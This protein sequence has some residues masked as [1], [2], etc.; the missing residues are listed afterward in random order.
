MKSLIPKKHID[1]LKQSFEVLKKYNM[2]LNP[3]KCSFGVSS[4]KFRGH[5]VTQW[6]IEANSDQI[7]S[8]INI[9]SPTCIKK[10]QKLTG[11]LVALNRFTSRSS[12]KC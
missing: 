8:I 1:H 9:Q 3:S 6:G 12:E 2:K 5:L 7:Q 4:R 10:A 11:R